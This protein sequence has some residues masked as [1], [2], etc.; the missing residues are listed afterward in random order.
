LDFIAAVREG[1]RQFF[2]PIECAVVKRGIGRNHAELVDRD[3]VLKTIREAT[4]KAMSLVGKAK[5]FTPILPLEIKLKLYWSDFCDQISGLPSVERIDARI[6][7]K[8]ASSYL[9]ILFE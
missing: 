6:V 7:R 9:D 2:N 5:P 1:R 3:E 4:C 8:V